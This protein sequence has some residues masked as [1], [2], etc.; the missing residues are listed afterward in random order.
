[1]G[2]EY[3]HSDEYRSDGSERHDDH[4]P[5]GSHGDLPSVASSR[6]IAAT[7]IVHG[8]TLATRNVADFKGCE[9]VLVDP[10]A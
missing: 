3:E 7:A 2:H 6:K 10:F 1:M 5:D 8:L 4:Q 9:V